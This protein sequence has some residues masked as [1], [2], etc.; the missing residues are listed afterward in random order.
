MRRDEKHFS[1]GIW[2]G[3]EFEFDPKFEAHHDDDCLLNFD[4]LIAMEIQLLLEYDIVMFQLTFNKY[5]LT[6]L[7]A[8]FTSK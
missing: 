2:R 5:G 1:F 4:I 6:R 7:N 8:Y 3:F